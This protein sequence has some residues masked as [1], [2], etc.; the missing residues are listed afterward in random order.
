M[1]QI[2]I[3]QWVVVVGC[4]VV[5]HKQV[6]V[7]TLKVNLTNSKTLP[8][9]PVSM[10]EFVR[11]TIEPKLMESDI[12]DFYLGEN[13]SPSANNSIVKKVAVGKN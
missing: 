1:A 11:V 4:M 2:H 12:L 9:K 3:C 10:Q 7:E 5:G 13:S 6:N 8:S